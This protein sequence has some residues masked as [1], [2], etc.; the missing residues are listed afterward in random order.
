VNP[1]TG[2]RE[3]ILM[4]P[5]REAAMGRE[6]AQ[7]V[8]SEIGLVEDRALASY[9]AAI[10]HQLAARSPRQDVA[11]AFHVVSM[12]EANA[13]ALP[14]GY[15]Y[16]SRGLLA[17]T[18]SEDELANVMAHEVAH[19]AARHSAQRETRAL[20]TGLLATLGVIAAGALGGGGV[21]Q[22]AAQVGQLAAAG[23]IASYSRDQEREA[24]QIGQRL[25][26][27][28]GYDPS[29]MAE[30]LSSLEREATMQLGKAPRPSFFDSHPST[31]ERSSAAAGL[32]RTLVRGPATP[33][34]ATR[35]QFLGHLEGLLLGPDPREG[36]FQDSVFLHPELEFRVQLPSEWTLQN[37]RQAVRAVA[38]QGSALIELTGAGVGDDP[39]AAAE[40]DLAQ[41]GISIV[42]AGA[43]RIES[44]RAYRARA[45][46]AMQ[47][48]S[49]G[50]DLTWVA[51]GGAIYRV[52]GMTPETTFSRY[53]ELF[54]RTALSFRPLT[55]D[56]RTRLRERRL[57]LEAARDG[58][59]LE[60]LS[61]R[62]ANAWSVA[63]TAVMN[64]LVESA[65]L[66]AGQLIKIA[67]DQPY[68]P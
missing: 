41:Q 23:L 50:L 18:N 57:R 35:G 9:V 21:S 28:A 15:I 6:A 49:M 10:G 1:A 26:A 22:A 61:A 47:Q 58:E 5:E 29:A 46:A 44:L 39:R 63:Q 13:F 67:R 66:R 51:H 2:R 14:G 31:P 54:R 45:F 30:F 19:V 38:P 16:V 53:S 34:A 43:V 11:Y 20:G 60:Q 64:G 62:T 68:R 24:D 17:L 48:G 25:A 33:I 52:A 36:V 65:R 59:S 3:I 37:A 55:T 7:Q 12:P 32:A 27:T 4:S 40:R 42:E 8:A 56:E